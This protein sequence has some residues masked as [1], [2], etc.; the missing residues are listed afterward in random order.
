MAQKRKSTSLKR[1]ASRSSGSSPFAWFVAGLVCGLAIAG[2]SLFKGM[3]PRV[4]DT[5]PGQEPA[6]EAVGEPALIKSADEPAAGRSQRE[7]DFFT[8]LPEMEVVVPEQELANDHGREDREAV[9]QAPASYILQAGSFRSMSDADQ[10]KARLALL[11]SQANIEVV[12]VNGVRWHRVR[13]GPI[14]G[15]RK[16]DEMRRMLRDNSIDT[17][18]LKDSS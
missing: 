2:F 10:L 16:A 11:G 1:G 4:Q 3:I 15:A 8:V 12:T 17:L 7:F 14:E 18:I 5:L 6:M 9:D 13:I